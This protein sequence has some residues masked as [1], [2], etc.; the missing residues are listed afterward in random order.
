MADMLM[1]MNKPKEALE[2]YELSLQRSPRRLNTI[3]GAASAAEKA[4]DAT[5]AKTYYQQLLEVAPNADANL[6][7]AQRA[8][9]Y[10]KIS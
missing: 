7:I 1:Q 4:G 2:Q 5:K 3:F 10:L 8:K 6:E 9:S